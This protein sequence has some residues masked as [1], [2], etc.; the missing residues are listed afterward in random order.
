MPDSTAPAARCSPW[1]ED[2]APVRESPMTIEGRT[3][4]CL[5][6]LAVTTAS[7]ARLEAAYRAAMCPR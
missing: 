3:R 2:M 4:L 1:A 7:A 5:T 6:P